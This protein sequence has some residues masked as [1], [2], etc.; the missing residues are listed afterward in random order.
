MGPTTLVIPTSIA[1]KADYWW[2][3]ELKISHAIITYYCFADL[4]LTDLCELLF[5]SWTRSIMTSSHYRLPVRLGADAS[6]IEA[7]NLFIKFVIPPLLFITCVFKEAWLDLRRG[8]FKLSLC[9]H[10]VFK[11]LFRSNSFTEI[12]INV[13]ATFGIFRQFLSVD[14]AGVNWLLAM[15]WT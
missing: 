2:R 11:W 3:T 6:A 7:C 1:W 8:S 5:D 4:S 13:K 12:T 10:S 15:R 14:R 9:I